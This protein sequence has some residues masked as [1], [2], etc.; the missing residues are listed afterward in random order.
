MIREGYNST[1]LSKLEYRLGDTKYLT[2]ELPDYRTVTNYC[3]CTV[4]KETL[5]HI[6]SLDGS[7]ELLQGTMESCPVNLLFAVISR[8]CGAKVSPDVDISR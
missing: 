4:K 2:G 7:T 1:V 3:T 5:L 6:R 8:Q